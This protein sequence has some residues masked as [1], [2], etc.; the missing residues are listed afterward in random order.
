ME[1]TDLSYKKAYE[2][3]Q[4]I[5]SQMEN[6]QLQIDELSKNIKEAMDLISICKS[7]LNAI[8]VDVNSLIQ[9]IEK[10]NIQ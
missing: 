10:Q 2:Q 8:E 1:K 6:G 4:N 3:L 9:E 7:K 5:V